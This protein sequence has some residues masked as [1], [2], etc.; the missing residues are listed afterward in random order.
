MTRLRLAA[1]DTF[2]SFD[3]R[4]FR[5]FF[6][7]QLV[8]QAGTWMQSVAIAWVV[9][10]MTGSGVALGLV[11]AA[12]FLPILL[13]GAWAGVVADRVDHHRMMLATQAA[14]LALAT[15]L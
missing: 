4:N 2:R 15:T 1:H 5:L 14:F 8:S 11:T 7:G 3:S 6:A 13:I 10:Q 9:L 12:E